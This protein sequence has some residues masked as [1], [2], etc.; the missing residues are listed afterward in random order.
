MPG[1]HLRAMREADAIAG[2][3][4]ID[5]LSL[6][7]DSISHG[8]L[9]L[10]WPTRCVCCELPHALLCRDC[11]EAL[12]RIAAESACPRCG[13]PFGAVACTECWTAD[14]QVP[15][16]FA[17]ARCA[18][19][20]NDASAKLILAYKDGGERALAPILAR[21]LVEALEP[22]LLESSDRLAYV[23]ASSQA[24]RRRGFDHMERIAC[25]VSTL[26]RLERVDLLAANSRFDQREL[27]REERAENMAEAF[28]LLE[29]IDELPR[30]VLLID[31]VFTTGATLTA[32]TEVLLAGGVERVDVGAICRVW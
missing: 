4:R 5:R 16:P 12:P 21:L 24:L 10:A 7:I 26:T 32:A 23:P 29:G 1:A 31:D 6:A 8:L 13:A 3:R 2:L 15:R 11:E 28:E 22:E 14:G 9:E 25:E 20:F 17:S 19:E 30:R 27:S 18:L